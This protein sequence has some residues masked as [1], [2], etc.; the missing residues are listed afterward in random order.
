MKNLS[1]IILIS[2]FSSVGAA[3]ELMC[4]TEIPSTS[5]WLRTEG[6]KLIARVIHHYGPQYAPMHNGMVTPNDLEVLKP[7]AEAVK[8]LPSDYEFSWPAKNC[9]F[10]AAYRMDCM[11]SS[12][13]KTIN[14]VKLEPWGIYTGITDRTNI[15][16]RYREI[17]VDLNLEID[18]VNVF[19]SMSYPE[20][21]CSQSGEQT[22]KFKKIFK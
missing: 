20:G 2:L 3:Y 18:D 21:S 13:T 12:D 22:P 6:D 5:F 4:F 11:N 1:L 17:N 19:I 14:G 15:A 16:G 8:K 7:R 10:P 9:N